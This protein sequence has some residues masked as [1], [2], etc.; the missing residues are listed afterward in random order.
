MTS[1]L[2]HHPHTQLQ[3]DHRKRQ[4]FLPKTSLS[5]PHLPKAAGM[6]AL[7]P[8]MDRRQ[9]GMTA[10]ASSATP[11]PAPTTARAT[12]KLQDQPLLIANVPA[13]AR[14]P[15]SLPEDIQIS[16]RPSESPGRQPNP[17]SLPGAAGGK[18]N[19]WRN[20]AWSEV[21][22]R[23]TRKCKKH[24]I[25]ATSDAWPV[26]VRCPVD[27]RYQGD[28]SSQP[29]AGKKPPPCST[30]YS[31]RKQNH[32]PSFSLVSPLSPLLNHSGIPPY[33]FPNS[34]RRRPIA[35]KPSS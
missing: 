21:G 6:A 32:P 12:P 15:Q 35:A 18:I 30:K 17:S 4:S 34:T 20:V 8:G 2:H 28:I 9:T 14:H 33:H 25:A 29:S 1:L 3:P 10:P 11:T 5:H 23:Q 26:K 7:V 22:T 19:E 16:G 13:S 27:D 31:P 24:E